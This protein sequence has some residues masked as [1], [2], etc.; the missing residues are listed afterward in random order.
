M[1][2]RDVLRALALT[3][4]GQ[5]IMSVAQ[6]APGRVY[7][8]GFLGVTSAVGYAK[9]VDAFREGMR[10]LGYVDG[11]NLLIEFRWAENR[12]ERLPAL[13]EELARLKVDLMVAQGTAGSH[14]AKAATSTIPI[15]SAVVGDAVGAGL[16]QS[17]ARP[18]GN[19]TGSTFFAPEMMVKQLDLLKQALPRAR[20]V[21]V[22]RDAESPTSRSEL[23]TAAS[24]LKVELIS[25]PVRAPAEFEAAF[26]A[27]GKRR[28]D[29]V[30]VSSDS[31]LVANARALGGFSSA[32][33][34]PSAGFIEFA[35]AG[36]L[37]GYGVNFPA[38]FRRAAVF[39]DKIFKGASAGELPFER[40]TNFGLVVNMKT[41]KAMG[42]AIPQS[43]LVRADRVIE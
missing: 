27:M 10:E 23:E 28:V 21:A 36:G 9:Q 18:G 26:A 25:F 17:L 8:I 29:A 2:R 32:H 12:S 34:I 19:I 11:K 30:V 33:R 22:L 1:K 35:E 5:P 42:L 40:A 37:I 41:A 20:S 4:I 13:A 14:A 43:V 31:L 16:A 38:M 39:A 3:A 15:V 6:P 7:K 24:S